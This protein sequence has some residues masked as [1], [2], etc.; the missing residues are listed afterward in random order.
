MRY[1]ILGDFNIDLLKYSEHLL[2]EEY[3][4][5]LYSNNLLPLITKPTRLTHHTSTLI[6]HIYP[7]SNLRVDAG[8]VL[9]DISDHLPVFCLLD[10]QIPRCK[11][12]LY[13]RDY[14]KFDVDQYI[15]DVNAVDWMN[16]CNESNDIHE[17][18][19][20]CISILKQIADKHVPIK[21]ASQSKRRQLAKPWL[22]RGVLISVKHKQKL[23][24]S[25][26]LSSDPDKMREYKLYANALNRIKNKA[27]NDYYCQRF[28][29]YQSDLKNT[30]KVIGTLVKRKY[31]GQNCPVRIVRNNKVFTNQSYIVEQFKQHFIN[32]G[33]NLAKTI[34]ST[35]DDTCGLINHSP[36]HSLF[37]SPVP[38]ELV[39]NFFS[40]LNDKKSSLNVPNKLVRLASKTLSKPFTYIFNKSISTGV[41]PDVFKVSKVAPIFK[42]ETLSDPSNYRP[43]ATLSP[44]SKALERVIYDQLI[45]YLDMHGVLLKYQFGF[46]K[47]HSTEQAIVEITDNLKASI[48]SNFVS[49]GL[50]LDFSKAFD[51]V[52]HQILLDKLCKYGIRG[53]PHDWFASYLQDRKQFV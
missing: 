39:A 37:L 21:H 1:Y 41:V 17:E 23:Y 51:T 24:K 10:R 25:H 42:S 18:A 11:R 49:C 13:F 30:W 15:K 38:E 28:N 22:T 16:V 33:P 19:A 36:L 12:A 52:N 40:C 14:S 53:R 26:F 9:V 34:H 45:L 6:D 7:N 20:N 2:T 44:F 4:N 46:R 5:M 31:K 35:D 27:K 43:I 48:D 50:F 29:F 32:V 8:V 3:L 47:K